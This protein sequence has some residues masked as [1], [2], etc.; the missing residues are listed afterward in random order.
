[1]RFPFFVCIAVCRAYSR[2]RFAFSTAFGTSYPFVKKTAI[3]EDSTQP[4]PRKPVFFVYSPGSVMASSLYTRISCA[5]SGRCPP[6]TSTYL[7]PSSNIS[8]P[9]FFM[10]SSEAIVIS[11][12]R[13]ASGIFG[14]ITSARGINLDFSNTTASGSRGYLRWMKLIQ[15]QALH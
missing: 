8:L 11:A 3:A 14:V 9:A 10:S 6:L 15:D 13:S 2:Q 5:F 1:M 4:V 7:H 12:N